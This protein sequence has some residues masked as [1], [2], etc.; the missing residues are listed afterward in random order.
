MGGIG[1]LTT[2]NVLADIDLDNV[3]EDSISGNPANI[4]DLGE[5]GTVI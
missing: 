1:Y 3:F 4:P 5:V 2:I